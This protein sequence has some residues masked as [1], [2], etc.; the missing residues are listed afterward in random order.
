MRNLT[1]AQHSD[2]VNGYIGSNDHRYKPI[3]FGSSVIL[4]K[5]GFVAV[6]KDLLIHDA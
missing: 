1:S 4:Y 3:A 2:G 5:I 6:S